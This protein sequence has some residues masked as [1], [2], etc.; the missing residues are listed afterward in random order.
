MASVSRWRK[1][2]SV[3]LNYFDQ[4]MGVTDPLETLNAKIFFDFRPIFG[5]VD[6]GAK[7]RDHITDQ[8]RKSEAFLKHIVNDCL[9]IE[10]PLSFFRNFIVERDGE[11]KNRLDLKLRGLTPVVDFA[12]VMALKHGKTSTNTIDRLT[13]LLQDGFIDKEICMDLLEA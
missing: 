7:L 10:P 8:A 5:A 3:W 4:W 12:R 13:G 2:Y 6:L 1:S 9:T 11:H